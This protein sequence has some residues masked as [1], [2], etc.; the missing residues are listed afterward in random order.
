MRAVSILC[1]IGVLF[2]TLGYAHLVTHFLTHTH[3]GQTHQ[4]W[5]WALSALAIA[6]GIFSAVGGFLLLTGKPGA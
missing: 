1:G 4:P 2:T 5:F 3:A 6:A